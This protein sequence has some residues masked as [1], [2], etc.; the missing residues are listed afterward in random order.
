VAEFNIDITTLQPNTI[1][2]VLLGSDRTAMEIGRKTE[3]NSL[4]EGIVEF[5]AQSGIFI[6]DNDGWNQYEA[7]IYNGETWE[8]Y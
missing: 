8:K 5:S 7:Y 3:H 6:H 1:Y 2:Y 4:F